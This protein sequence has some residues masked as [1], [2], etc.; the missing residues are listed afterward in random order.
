MDNSG[1]TPG[2]A[3]RSCL[4]C[5]EM[6][7]TSHLYCSER[8]EDRFLTWLKN[9]PSAIRGSRPP[10]WNIIRRL[11][12]E[13]DDHQCKFCGSVSDLSVHH[14]IPLAAGGDSTLDNLRVLCHACHQKEH[15]LR[16]HV[17]RKNRFRIRIRHQ[18]MF[19]PI[20]SFGDWISHH[21]TEVQS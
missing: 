9:E 10:F 17:P 13:R 5:D 20:D 14:I 16:E 7:G 3:G 2:K 11:A 12:L 8:C 15:G 21:D 1:H 4:W 18:P 6:T 19:L